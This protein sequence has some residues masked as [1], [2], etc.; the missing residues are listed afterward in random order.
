M[1]KLMLLMLLTLFACSLRAQQSDD[2]IPRSVWTPTATGTAWARGV[3]EAKSVRVAWWSYW[4]PRADGTWKLMLERCV[5]GRACIDAE[6]ATRLLDTA[7]RSA[8]PLK[9]LAAARSG[10]RAP[11]APDERAAWDLAEVDAVAAAQPLRPA[12]PAAPSPAASAAYI[13]STATSA[14]GTR[15]AYPF[16]NG[17]RG[18]TSNSRA[19]AGQPCDPAKGSA[20]AAGGG[21]WSVFGPAFDVSK[22][23]L[24]VGAR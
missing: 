5:V 15:P 9:S 19:L 7:A 2:C 10:L 20:P 18:T 14:D 21:I 3:S 17:V 11:V 6:T 1:R 22:V 8:D 12:S 23:A 13:V 4:C 16:V 24:C